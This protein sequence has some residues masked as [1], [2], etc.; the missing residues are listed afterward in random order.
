[1]LFKDFK[2]NTIMEIGEW[3][4]SGALTSE[5][6][7]QDYILSITDFTNQELTYLV[8][9]T[10]SKK[11]S[12]LIAQKN[13]KNGLGGSWEEYDFE[14]TDITFELGAARAY[15][16]Q[17]GGSGTVYI[18][19]ETAPSVWTL[20]DA[21]VHAHTV[22][23]GYVLYKGNVTKADD[24]NQL[25]LR[26]SGTYD[27]PF[28][29][30]ALFTEYKEFPVSY[31][32]QLEYDSPSDL[33]LLERVNILKD[34]GSYEEYPSSMYIRAGKKI[35]FP[36]ETEGEFK[37]EYAAY[38]T[39]LEYDE[40][41]V[42]IADDTELDILDEYLTSLINSVAGKLKANVDKK[43]SV[44]DRYSSI[45]IDAANATLANNQK[46]AVETPIRRK[47]W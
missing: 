9:V 13:P 34:D 2:R 27:Y 26:F 31:E 12:Y 45:G 38:P 32:S 22:G 42:N 35:I 23:D 24:A 21:I 4:A 18:E 37:V 41:N 15:S 46:R 36:Y 7:K 28:R 8:T 20:I 17:I 5:A 3:S 30:V 25:R 43:Y 29:W 39:L 19:E 14:G 6:S 10:K 11:E 47:R 16:L 33:Y 40:N 44:G 1:M